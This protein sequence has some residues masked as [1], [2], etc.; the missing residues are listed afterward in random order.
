MLCRDGMTKLGSNYGLTEKPARPIWDSLKLIL[1]VILLM[2]AWSPVSWA[3]RDDHRGHRG[4]ANPASSADPEL[5]FGPELSFTN[6]KI[7]ET[8]GRTRQTDSP[9]SVASL[10]RFRQ[11]VLELCLDEYRVCRI[12]AERDAK[13]YDSYR[14][15]VSAHGQQEAW[16]FRLSYDPGVIEVQMQP[17]T[18]AQLQSRQSLIQRL[19]FDAADLAELRPYMWAGGG[20]LHLDAARAFGGDVRI[21]RDFIVDMNNHAAIFLFLMRGSPPNAP[22]IWMLPE[23]RQR[24]FARLLAEVDSRPRDWRVETLADAIKSRV[25]S[26]TVENWAPADKYQFMNLVRLTSRGPRGFAP[27]AR[28]TEVRGLGPQYSAQQLLMIAQILE[29]RLKWIRRRAERGEAPL[30]WNPLRYPLTTGY[31]TQAPPELREAFD[32]YLRESGFRSRT[33]FESFFRESAPEPNRLCRALFTRS[34]N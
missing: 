3:S 2:G 4:T 16:W 14:V 1:L 11:R 15:D 29:A 10:L 8:H 13:G 23:A 26:E 19:I 17:S 27:S 6:E 28:T 5:L 9:A 18:L 20:H 24:S 12:T 25:Y 33:R 34:L 21:F 30:A 7:Q 22:A 32:R 31:A